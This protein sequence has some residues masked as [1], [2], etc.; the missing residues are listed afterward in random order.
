MK[1]KNEII[2]DRDLSKPE[3]TMRKKR[4]RPANSKENSVNNSFNNDEERGTQKKDTVITQNNVSNLKVVSPEN[5]NVEDFVEDDE[6]KKNNNLQNQKEPFQKTPIKLTKDV[7]Q[8]ID[9]DKSNIDNN[10]KDNNNN[11]LVTNEKDK[12]KI[13]QENKNN[14]ITNGKENNS[15]GGLYNNGENKNTAQNVISKGSI[16]DNEKIDGKNN[17]NNDKEKEQSNKDNTDEKNNKEITSNTK[18][19]E[20]DNK[21]IKEDNV[22][23]NKNM[24]PNGDKEGILGSEELPEQET[25]K[26]NLGQLEGTEPEHNVSNLQLGEHP[27]NYEEE[28]G[29]ENDIKEEFHLREIE[30]KERIKHLEEELHIEKNKA[31]ERQKLSPEDILNSIRKEIKSK[32]REINKYICLN[33]KQ[34]QELEKISKEID[35]KLK[36]VSYKKITDRIKKERKPIKDEN[37]EMAIKLLE[38]QLKNALQLV[39]ILTKDNNMLKDKF[40]K[41]LDYQARY[42][43]ADK[44][45]ENDTTIIT[46]N[47][48]IKKLRRQLEE[49]AKCIK[50][51]DEYEKNIRLTREDLR[52]ANLRNEEIKTKI[53]LEEDLYN[54][55]K[56]KKEQSKSTSKRELKGAKTRRPIRIII[57]AKTET[58]I[59]QGK[60]YFSKREQ[61]YLLDAF[62]GDISELNKY[63]KKISILHIYSQ[64][65]ESKQKYEMKSYLSKLND[66]DEQIEY[67]TQKN[68]DTSSKNHL[69]ETQISD[70]KADKAAYI[71]KI[72]E[73]NKSISAMNV[74]LKQKEAEI[75]SLIEKLNTLRELIKK[76]KDQDISGDISSYI[77][78]VKS[79]EKEEPIFFTEQGVQLTES[80]VES[81]NK[82]EKE[83]K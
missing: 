76:G 9:K 16:S 3:K 11:I 19:E 71:R 48:E 61:E 37:P 79:E 38:S 10:N 72:E 27:D 22:V 5:Q 20:K 29:E 60:C 8:A 39:E 28:Y 81:H 56:Q 4:K 75:R 80:N 12:D 50:Q 18:I 13:I 65:K 66:M 59:E 2:Y 41:G 55:N 45:K 64:S 58:S 62:D 67:L 42:Q 57:D 32:D 24:T 63:Y 34:R 54:V 46:L 77:K 14:V 36:T 73:I 44:S 43:L 25:L 69:L 26:D 33:T 35:K 51:K 49:H 52:M 47:M 1:N 53:K 74:V 30:Y 40:A 78:K 23:Q 83:V 68:K 21:E 15:N 7:I 70:Y 82:I 31:I 6:K 17:N